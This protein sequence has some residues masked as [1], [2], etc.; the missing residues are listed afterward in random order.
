MVDL[1]Y[2]GLPIIDYADASRESTF[3]LSWLHLAAA[4]DA[5]WRH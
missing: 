2:G 5:A 4:R 1:P 3:K